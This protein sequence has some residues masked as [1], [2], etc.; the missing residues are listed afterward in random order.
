MKKFILAL[1]LL[2]CLAG[3]NTKTTTEDGKTTDNTSSDSTTN[4][5]STTA[6][7]TSTEEQYISITPSVLSDYEMTTTVPS[8]AIYCNLSEMTGDLEIRAE[9]N[10]LLEGTLN[11]RIYVNV[12]GQVHL[13]LNGVTINS[14]DGAGIAIFGSKKKVITLMDGTVNTINDNSIYSKFENVDNDEPNAAIFCKKALTINGNGTLIVN[15][16]GTF[17]N[18]LGEAV[19][20]HGI[21]CKDALRILNNPT[22]NINAKG[23]GI[24]GKDLVEI[25]EANI[26]ILAEEDGIKSDNILEGFG[27]IYLNKTVLNITAGSKD[28]KAVNGIC[29]I[30]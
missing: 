7:N 18:A 27:Y 20:A 21:N 3:C 23:N 17:T 4:N 22:I 29:Y 13:Y 5:D 10:Y 2:F 9:G 8:S 28:L 14:T 6:N 15:A 12:V 24:K 30:K 11:G 1:L 25:Y 19:N 16:Q 26:V